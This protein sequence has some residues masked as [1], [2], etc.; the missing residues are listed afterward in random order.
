MKPD[1]ESLFI[2]HLLRKTGSRDL[3]RRTFHFGG[4][5]AAAGVLVAGWLASLYR[6]RI[7]LPLLAKTLSFG[8]V[9]LFIFL[10][11]LLASHIIPSTTHEAFAD[12]LASA[13]ATPPPPVA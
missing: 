3:A 9:A 8:N 12:R 7:L 4:Y 11:A 13:V 6:R 1:D 5:S 10:S 2:F